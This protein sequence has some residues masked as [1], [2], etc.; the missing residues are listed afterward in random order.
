MEN[1]W[2]KRLTYAF[3]CPSGNIVQIRR[4]GPSLALK[5]TKAARIFQRGGPEV[6]TDVDSQLAF[7]EALPDADV[8][9]IYNFARIMLTDVVAEPR[10][11]LN[12]SSDQLSPDDVPV[13]DFW[14]IF[15]STSNGIREMPVKLK[16]GETTVDAVETFPSEQAGS[17]QPDDNS[18]AV[19]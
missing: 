8:D 13:A 5:G 7:I 17:S 16:D 3:T 12:P 6:L 2:R 15:I 4:P 11:Y 19:Q 14:A 1:Q 10:L 18:E 9:E